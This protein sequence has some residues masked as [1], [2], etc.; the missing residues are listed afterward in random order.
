MKTGKILP[1]SQKL[2]VITK[3]NYKSALAALAKL[4][5]GVK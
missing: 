5:K 1:N 3:E 4:T 2:S